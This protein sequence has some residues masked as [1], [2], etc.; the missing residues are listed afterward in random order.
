V[1]GVVLPPGPTSEQ[2]ARNTRH[3]LRHYAYWHPCFADLLRAHPESDEEREHR[4]QIWDWDVRFHA[5]GAR[6]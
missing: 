2:I 6:R 4:E 3:C 1:I 5:E